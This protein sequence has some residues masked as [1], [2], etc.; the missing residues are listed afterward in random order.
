MFRQREDSIE[1]Y[2]VLRRKA[3]MSVMYIFDIY[4]RK[5]SMGAQ[6]QLGARSSA[7]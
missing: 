1:F 4:D 2:K 3:L 7:T 5:K 6:F